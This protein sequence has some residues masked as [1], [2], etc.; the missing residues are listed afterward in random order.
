MTTRIIRRILK[1]LRR[2]WNIFWPLLL[3]YTLLA[4]LPSAP[5]QRVSEEFA[6]SFQAED[7]Y[8]DSAGKERILCIDDNEEALL[9]RLRVIETAQEEIVFST[10][11]MRDDNSG[12]DVTAALYAAAERGVHVRILVD[13]LTGYYQLHDSSRFQALVSHENVEAKFYNPVNL[14][15]P[16][17]ISY[18][19]HDKYLMADDTVYILG[20][21]NTYDLFL[22]DYAEKANIDRD[23]LVYETDTAAEGT[24]LAQVQAYFEEIWELSCCKEFVCEEISEEMQTAVVSLEEHYAWLGETYPEAYEETDYAAATMETNQV[25]LLANPMEAENREPELWTMLQE[26]MTGADDVVIQTPYIVCSRAMYQNLTAIC[27]SAGSVEIITNAVESGANPFGCTDY[28]NQKEN[29]LETGVSVCEFLG[30]DSTHVKT[31]LIDDRLSVVGS[32]NLDMRSTYLDTEMMLAIDCEEL[33][34]KLRAETDECREQS[35]QL[36]PDGTVQYGTEYQAVELTTKK[37]VF[38]AAFRIF[39]W[40]IRYLL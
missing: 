12:Q 26:L 35:K 14:A 27:E 30:D 3:I 38:Y 25:T 40:P 37:K 20:G 6:S 10:F 31:F 2:L 29:I 19:L 11:E 24:S 5:H 9:W 21:R 34:E 32:Y 18:R 16:W 22:G 8:G 36:A 33:N 17:K 28:L 15:R 1:G 4:I 23:I 39:I 7:C 13:G